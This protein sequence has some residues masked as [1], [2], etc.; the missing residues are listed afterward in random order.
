MKTLSLFFLLSFGVSALAGQTDSD[1]TG[2]NDSREKQN[3]ESVKTS[4]TKATGVV[5]K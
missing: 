5:K 1:C 3:K 2:I 4:Q